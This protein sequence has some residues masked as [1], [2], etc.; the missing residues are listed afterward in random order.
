[1]LQM[2]EDY[3]RICKINEF[4]QFSVGKKKLKK[5]TNLL[6]THMRTYVERRWNESLYIYFFLIPLPSNYE[7]NWIGDELTFV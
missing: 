7:L 3:N 1:M 2:V 6:C 4:K 5:I